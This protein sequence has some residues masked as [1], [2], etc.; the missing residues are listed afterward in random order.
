MRFAAALA[1]AKRDLRGLVPKLSDWLKEILMLRL[2]LETHQ[3]PYPGLADD[4]AALLP[5]DFLRATPFERVPHLARYLRGMQARAERWK[6]DAAKDATRA[7][8][9]GPFTAVLKKLGPAAGEVDRK[10]VV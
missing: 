3:T 2:A 10:S 6:R 8:E 1:E 4:L 7:K 9:L 5:P